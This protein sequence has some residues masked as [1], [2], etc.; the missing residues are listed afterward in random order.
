MQGN[1]EKKPKKFEKLKKPFPALCLAKT[2][3]DRPRKREKTFSPEFRSHSTRARKFQKKKAKKFKKLKNPF[4]V[5][6]LAKMGWDWPRKREKNFT[7]EFGSY[8]TWARKCQRKSSK[9][10]QKI[11]KVNSD[12][13]SIQNG[14]GERPWK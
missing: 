12:I 6:F 1:S 5:L 9:K 4:P 11:K 3:L 14:L 10:I 8:P 2:G 7:P 13:I